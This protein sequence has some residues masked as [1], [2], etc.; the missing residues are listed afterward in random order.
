MSWNS[1]KPWLAMLVLFLLTGSSLAQV[2]NERRP[3]SILD[4][5]FLLPHRYLDHLTADSRPVREAA[6]QIKDLDGRFLKSGPSA[7][8]VYTALALFKKSDGSDLM[9][10][11]NRSCPS[12]C[13][14]TLNLLSYTNGRWTDV[15]H[16]L[17]PAIDGGKIQ[18]L[19]QR[20]YLIRPNEPMRPPQVIYTLRKNG[21]SIEAHEHWSG[22]VLGEYEWANDAFIFKSEEVLGRN[23]RVLAATDNKEG[24]RLQIIGIDPESLASLPLNGHLRIR[25]AYQLK[26]GK[27]GFIWATP[28]I[29]EQRLPDSFT[30]GSMPYKPGSGVTTV[31]FGFNNQAHLDVLRVTMADEQRKQILTLTYPIDA[32]WKGS[33]R[34]R[35]SVLSAFRILILPPAR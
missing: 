20:Q 14:S 11:E 19:L 13:A 7:D 24:D 35:S 8:E 28:V 32:N 10:V 23:Y 17:L 9:A 31:W 21:G 12:G 25:I 26:S 1:C 30:S 4:Y 18:A 22:M 34:V 2:A 27:H 5:Y 16:D 33:A 29:L 3:T 15:T 6:I